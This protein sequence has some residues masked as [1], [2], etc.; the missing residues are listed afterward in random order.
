M[1]TLSYKQFVG[2]FTTYRPSRMLLTIAFTLS[3]V[4][5]GLSLVIPLIA[6]DLVNLLIEE[7]FNG[8]LLVG[9]V[10]LFVTQVV[11]SGLSLYLM[12]YIGEKVIVRLRDDLWNRVVRLPLT[13][14]DKNNSG[15]IMSRITNDTNVMKNFFIDHLVPSLQLIS[16][17]GSFI[18]LFVLNWSMALLFLI[19]FPLA[20]FV[21]KPLGKRM[22]SVS[23]DLQQETASFQGDLSRVLGDVRLVKFS[24]AEKQ[25]AAEGT[26]RATKLY[27]YGLSTGKIL[28]IVAPLMTAIILLVLVMII[29]YGGYQV[30]TGSLSAGALVAVVFTSFKLLILFP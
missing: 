18:I 22:Y 10:L 5:T 24:V 1:K 25:E 27:H 8:L 30:A 29:G 15:E 26:K 17:I 9:L 13:F 23:R 3:L 21:I 19:I 6:M 4:Q 14:Y 2:I 20:F 28:A 11:L 12:I 16:I 7:S